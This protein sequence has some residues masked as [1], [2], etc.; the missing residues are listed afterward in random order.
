MKKGFIIAAVVLIS[1]GIILFVS[2]LI[3]S[4]FDFKGAGAWK[5]TV[6]GLDIAE[7]FHN[8][9]IETTT[10]DVLLIRSENG[11]CRVVYDDIDD[12]ELTA[13]VEN[14][15]LKVNYV[16]ERK[17]FDRITLWTPKLTVTVYLPA[18][19]FESVAVASKTGDILISDLEAD[20]MALA[21]TTG[22]I[23]LS[24]V[25][26]S[27]DLSAAVTTGE[28]SVSDLTCRNLVSDG[29]TGDISLSNVI[30][31]ERMDLKR[32]TGDVHFDKCDAANIKVKTSTGDVSGSLL[33]GK[34]FVAKSSTGRVSVPDSS[35]G[36]QCEV[37]TS[38]GDIKLQVIS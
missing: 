33:S 4:G 23:L 7:P 10:A 27:K 18:S 15:V 31:S 36:G 1:L 5:T 11:A 30:A 9:T 38:T 37:T 24:S 6:K 3:A 19:S 22:D 32:S 2:A 13:N 35:S 26:L 34:V 20:N 14:G 16:D 17:W 29:S 25:R 12:L 21:V 8:V 28:L